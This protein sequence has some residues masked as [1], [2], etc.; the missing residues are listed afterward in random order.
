MPSTGELGYQ[1]AFLSHTQVKLF[2]PTPAYSPV[3][4]VRGSHYL[5]DRRAG[6]QNLG[7]GGGQQP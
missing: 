3:T 6:N 1:G 5:P 7:V 4:H 2:S